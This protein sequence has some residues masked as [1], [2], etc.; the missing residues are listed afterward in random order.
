LHRPSIFSFSCIS[1]YAKS[2]PG[3]ELQ[4]SEIGC[5]KEGEI[6]QSNLHKKNY[7]PLNKMNLDS[8]TI[9]KRTTT[10][11]LRPLLRLKPSRHIWHTA[12]ILGAPALSHIL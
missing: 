5:K 11:S 8:R 6:Q 12:A 7:E 10:L 4:T 1:A 9:I 3:K 2:L